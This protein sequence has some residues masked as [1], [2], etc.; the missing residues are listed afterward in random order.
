MRLAVLV[1]VCTLAVVIDGVTEGDVAQPIELSSR[2]DLGAEPQ[3]PGFGHFETHVW[4]PNS[5]EPNSYPPRAPQAMPPPSRRSWQVPHAAPPCSLFLHRQRPQ[6]RLYSAAFGA[7]R[8]LAAYWP[9]DGNF[10]D[11]ISLKKGKVTGGA[12]LS[13]NGMVGQAV[14]LTG[15]GRVVLT[16]AG[17]GS[18]FDTKVLLGTVVHSVLRLW[19]RCFR[20]CAKRLPAPHL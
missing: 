19:D 9:L 17:K 6:G 11:V 3:S 15:T 4:V 13:K 12:K 18:V 5:P 14:R 1:L 10:E 2:A 16:T 8:G 7:P 20:Y